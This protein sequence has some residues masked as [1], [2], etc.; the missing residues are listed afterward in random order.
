MIVCPVCGWTTKSAAEMVGHM[1]RHGK[2]TFT[3]WKVQ[4]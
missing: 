4:R 2:F 1:S 3:L